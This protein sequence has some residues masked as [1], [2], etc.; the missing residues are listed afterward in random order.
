MK[1]RIVIKKNSPVTVT[2]EY[3][4]GFS[5]ITISVP[6]RI[7]VNAIFNE[8]YYMNKDKYIMVNR[9]KDVTTIIS[10]VKL[11]YDNI[12]FKSTHI[13]TKTRQKTT[14]Q[15]NQAKWIDKAKEL[16]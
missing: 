13:D 6:S 4:K 14:R 2:L 12:L 16:W 3:S 15:Y 5:L 10:L 8:G 1:A 7:M 11:Q 9:F